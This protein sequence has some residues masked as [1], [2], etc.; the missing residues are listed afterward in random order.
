MEQKKLFLYGESWEF[1]VQLQQKFYQAQASGKEV[2]LYYQGEFYDSFNITTI[3]GNEC[4]NDLDFHFYFQ[5][6]ANLNLAESYLKL[7]WAK[8]EKE[9][10][11]SELFLETM[12]NEE[13]ILQFLQTT[14]DLSSIYC[15][16]R[17]IC[18]AYFS[19][20]MM[21]P[22]YAEYLGIIEARF[23]QVQAKKGIFRKKNK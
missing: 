4:I 21:V 5:E 23:P 15:F 7:K 1:P 6:L 20:G 2:S 8:E 11:P 9:K 16:F 10:N 14:S 19:R 12:P 3:G 18:V 22:H 13:R 17:Q